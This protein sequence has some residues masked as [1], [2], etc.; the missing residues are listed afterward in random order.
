MEPTSLATGIVALAGLFNNAI[1]C[2]EYV[3]L[4]RNFGKN[5]QTSLL[6]LDSASFAAIA[7][8]RSCRTRWRPKKRAII[9]TDIA[10]STGRG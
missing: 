5:F 7:M 10:F 4:G 2:F 3:Q 8:G 9:A 6:K 1:D